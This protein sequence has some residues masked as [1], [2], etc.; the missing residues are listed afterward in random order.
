M[1]AQLDCQPQDLLK[2]AWSARAGGLNAQLSGWSLFVGEKTTF[3]LLITTF[4]SKPSET[5]KRHCVSS[6]KCI[7]KDKV[8]AHNV[9]SRVL[10][11]CGL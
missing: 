9:I 10:N 11:V 8:G 4:V 2:A 3:S 7:K 6:D 1:A 5:L